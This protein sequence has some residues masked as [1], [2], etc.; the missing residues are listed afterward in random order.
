MTSRRAPVKK[1]RSK[2]RR[3]RVID[4]DRMEWLHT[5]PCTLA[6]HSLHVCGGWITVHHV[7][8]YGEPKDD[9]RG[10][11]LCQAAHLYDF[12]ADAIERIG[13]VKFEQTFGLDLE[14]QVKQYQERYEERVI[15]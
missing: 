14:A 5:L 2:P 1:R 9:T 15:A 7:R 3:G 13:K 8:R 10:I 12:G 6:G 11:P 4:K